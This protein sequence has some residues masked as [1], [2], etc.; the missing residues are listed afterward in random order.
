MVA[1][2][3]PKD[4]QKYSDLSGNSFNSSWLCGIRH[5]EHHSLLH[6]TPGQS[7]DGELRGCCKLL[8]LGSCVSL[9]LLCVSDHFC[10]V[11]KEVF[12]KLPAP[13][14]LEGTSSK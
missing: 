8:A 2:F 12:W 7:F 5:A 11:L 9:S 13:L 4:G 3:H 10:F 14:L 1:I 6:S